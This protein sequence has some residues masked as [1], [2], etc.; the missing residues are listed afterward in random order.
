VELR[1]ESWTRRGTLHRLQDRALYLFNE[2]L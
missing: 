1:L 2:Q